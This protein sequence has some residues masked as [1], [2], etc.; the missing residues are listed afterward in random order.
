MEQIGRCDRHECAQD[1]PRQEHAQ[2]A[3]GRRKQ[4]AFH[5]PLPNDGAASRAKRRPDG[6]FTAACRCASQQQVRDVEAGDREE[7]RD[8][9]RQRDERAVHLAGQLLAQR[10]EHDGRVLVE[11]ILRRHL[12]G[13]N[14]HLGSRGH[15]GRCRPEASDNLEE[16]PGR[17]APGLL[18]IELP[19]GP[20]VGVLEDE[21]E[22]RGHDADDLDRSVIELDGAANRTSIAGQ[23]L[24]PEFVAD[25]GDG[26]H[27]R[28]VIVRGEDASEPRV[29]PNNGKNS[30]ETS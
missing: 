25:H 22:P 8:R 24:L 23:A 29:D 30:A 19:G 9:D 12:A 14:L 18:S 4:Q 20:Q 2:R 27:V 11:R 21:P 7:H 28:S 13:E 26:R 10:H 6:H 5:E 3:A 15:Q 17:L 1:P 16:A